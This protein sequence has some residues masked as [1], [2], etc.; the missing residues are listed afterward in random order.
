MD[1]STPSLTVPP[2]LAEFV[3]VHVGIILFVIGQRTEIHLDF[4]VRTKTELVLVRLV[5]KGINPNKLEEC[6]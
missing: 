3:Q 2:H 6:N 5:E 4:I 1:C